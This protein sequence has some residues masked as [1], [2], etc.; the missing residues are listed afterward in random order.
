MTRAPRPRVILVMGVAGS[1]KSTVGKLL[2]DALRARFVEGDDAHPPG[3]VERMRR[4]IALTDRE[5]VP[6][7]RA[8]RGSLG[9]CVQRGEDV[10]LA[11][12]ALKRAH[13]KILLGGAPPLDAEITVVH[14]TGDPEL[15]RRRI[16]KR[17]EHYFPP[18]LLDDQLAT[19]EPPKGALT[20]DV[21][22]PAA[23]I[24]ADVARRLEP[25]E[26]RPTGKDQRAALRR[27]LLEQPGVVEQRSKFGA[28]QAFHAD[29]KEF[30]HFHAESVI[31][32]RVPR[33]HQK[34]LRDDPRVTFRPRPS[35]W[36]EF[37][38]STDD[39]VDTVVR[40]ALAAL[41]EA[42]SRARSRPGRRGR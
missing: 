33:A 9:A 13:R 42:R 14:L 29:G 28:H 37:E 30:A 7:L 24:A 16:A 18:H 19:L 34:A 4:G 32:V 23:D 17:P 21:A 31:D 36:V 22:Q 25:P 41:D 1:G 2:A 20:C 27:K 38:F 35:G 39:D 40:L 6:W 12:S 3:N 5:R 8:L 15:L 11:C 10:V 26:E